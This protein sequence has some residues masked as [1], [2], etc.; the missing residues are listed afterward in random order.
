MRPGFYEEHFDNADLPSDW[1]QEDQSGQGFEWEYCKNGAPCLPA[2]T[3]FSSSTASDGFVIMVSAPDQT[4][5]NPHISSLYSP[6]FDFSDK[7]EVILEF[8][9]LIRTFNYNAADHAKLW[10]KVN[11]GFWNPFTLFH[12]MNKDY[13]FETSR[14]PRT[15]TVNISDLAAGKNEV[16]LKWEWVGTDEEFW[17]I[18]DVKLYDYDPFYR[19][20]VWGQLPGQGDFKGGWNGWVE[21][22]I[23]ANDKD[24]DKWIWDSIGY[25]GNALASKSSLFGDNAYYPYLDSRTNQNGAAVFNADFFLTGGTT[26]VMAPYPYNHAEL[27][28][29][30]IDL[31]NV[32]EEVALQFSQFAMRLNYNSPQFLSTFNVAFS[33]DGGR[34]WQPSIPVNLGLDANQPINST[35]KVNLPGAA[36]KANLRVKFIYGG[37]QYFW[38][39]DDVLIVKRKENDLRLASNFFGIAPNYATPKSQVEQV[40]F[41][42]DVENA[43]TESQQG[44]KAKVT[45]RTKEQGILVFSDSLELGNLAPDSAYTDAFFNNSFLPP[46]EAQKYEVVYQTYSNQ[47]DEAPEDNFLSW[48]FEIT[49]NTYQKERGPTT[50]IRPISRPYNFEYGNCF[51]IP[52][53]RD[54]KAHEVTFGISNTDQLSGQKVTVLVY[55]F[56][57][58][59]DNN[60][61]I[62]PQ[63]YEIVGLGE[64]QIQGNEYLTNGGIITTRVYNLD[65][66]PGIALEDNTYYIISLEYV[67][68]SGF[69]CLVYASQEFD[70]YPMFY[71]QEKLGLHRYAAVEDINDNFELYSL[72]FDLI[73]LIRLHIIHKNTPTKNLSNTNTPIVYPNPASDYFIVNKFEGTGKLDL[74]DTS[75]K[76]VKSWDTDYWKGFFPINEV[77]AGNYFL[78]FTLNGDTLPAWTQNLSKQ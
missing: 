70:Y 46:A 78:K 17:C 7:N 23:E 25:I 26:P 28:S 64:Y 41:L 4:L 43:G 24:T 11:N 38:V 62:D 27:I 53:G 47:A 56:Y 57:S 40:R 50:Q 58:N 16:Q 59:D 73:P 49:E 13:Q 19:D 20:A 66:E 3:R 72:G 18:D 32:N 35:V 63:E 65:S 5:A 1:T 44:V 14:N 2:G 75:G 9:T 21:N 8:E 39:I 31:S 67:D 51:Y 34:N 15:I 76:K 60:S 6:V 42:C 22:T 68:F 29:P 52:K 33:L 36:G 10:I 77:P 69:A 61:F 55:K 48:S 54:Y 37:D 71:Q 74:F 45:V 12:E 30:N